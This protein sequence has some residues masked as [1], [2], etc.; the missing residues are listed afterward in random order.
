MSMN[1]YS[2]HL[3][4]H[5]LI[6]YYKS[7]EMPNFLN[8]IAEF[9]RIHLNVNHGGTVELNRRCLIDIIIHAIDLDESTSIKNSAEC[10][11]L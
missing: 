4:T 3:I 7:L 9:L 1:I 10:G 11:T 5:I 2:L 8:N 6:P